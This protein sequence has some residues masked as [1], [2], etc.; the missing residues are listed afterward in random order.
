MLARTVANS[1]DVVIPL[2]GYERR[3]MVGSMSSRPRHEA[4][5]DRV[6]HA[7]E[8]PVPSAAANDERALE[9]ARVWAAGGKQHVALATQ[10][11][12]D[13]ASWGI[14]LVDL[15]R[16]VANAYGASASGMTREAVLERIK[17]G[18]D[19]EWSHPTDEALNTTM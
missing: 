1:I 14:M 3:V 4:N 10:I 2:A 11:W 19:A 8:L 13:P 16:H 5:E 9:L 15:A 6:N 12:D 17:V 18:F 7:N